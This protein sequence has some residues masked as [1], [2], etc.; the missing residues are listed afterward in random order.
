L[1]N[2]V[3]KRIQWERG[4]AEVMAAGPEGAENFLGSRVLLTVPRGVLKRNEKGGGI[5]FDPTIKEK[6]EAIQSL[7]MGAVTKV[8]MEFRSRFWTVED[9]G[10]IHTNR[11]A[12]S[13]WWSHGRLPVL[14]G[15]AGG[16]AAESLSHQGYEGL[17]AEAITAL[18]RIFK[19]V[20]SEVKDHLIGSHFYDWTDD[21]FSRGAYSYTP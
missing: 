13:T 4:S 3:A 9:F 5:E 18:S 10:F 20:R 17:I 21:P 2:R 14:T 8:T 12:L 11:E 7:E 1:R 16:P 15:W 19:L 6:K